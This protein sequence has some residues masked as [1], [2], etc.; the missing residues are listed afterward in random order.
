MFPTAED[1]LN[2]ESKM[3]VDEEIFKEP[4]TETQSEPD[5]EEIAVREFS[6]NVFFLP[7]SEELQTFIYEVH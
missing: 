2:E 5:G 6:S 3:Q 1:L 4:E 7:I